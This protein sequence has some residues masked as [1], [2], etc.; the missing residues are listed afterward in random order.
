MRS[1]SFSNILLKISE[2]LS[3]LPLVKKVGEGD[4]V[5]NLTINLEHIFTYYKG[6]KLS[7]RCF[8]G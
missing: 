8:G 2:Y 4:L 6:E 7:L 5:P 1:I 3:S